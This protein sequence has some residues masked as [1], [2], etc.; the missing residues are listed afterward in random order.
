MIAILNP[1]YYCSILKMYVTCSCKFFANVPVN[2]I[3]RWFTVSIFYFIFYYVIFLL[4]WV[5]SVFW[6]IAK[7][8][9][10]YFIDLE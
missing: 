8:Y 7:K 4:V 3:E 2:K 1:G 5:K 10:P 9:H 6:S